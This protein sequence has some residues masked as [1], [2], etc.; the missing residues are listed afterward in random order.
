MVA[1]GKVAMKLLLLMINNLILLHKLCCAFW[2]HMSLQTRC[3]SQQFIG[4]C[5]SRTHE[6]WPGQGFSSRRLQGALSVKRQQTAPCH[7]QSCLVGTETDGARQNF[8]WSEKHRVS[9]LEHTYKEEHQPARTGDASWDG[10]RDLQR[11]GMQRGHV[12]GDVLWLGEVPCQEYMSPSHPHQGRDTPEGLQLWATHRRAGPGLRDC[13]WPQWG[14]NTEK[15]KKSRGK[16]ARSS[17]SRKKP[18]GIWPSCSAHPLTKGVGDGLSTTS[19]KNQGSQD[20]AGWGIWIKLKVRKWED[21]RGLIVCFLSIPKS[22]IRS[23][24]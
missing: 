12:A 6:A 8:S 23:L 5:C 24:C 13:K 19:S 4:T 16:S 10:L 14:R 9:L 2:R 20:R 18:L 21:V 3:M 15:Q 22:M 7:L 11:E 1:F 17:S